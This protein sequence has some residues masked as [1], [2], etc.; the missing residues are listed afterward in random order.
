MVRRAISCAVTILV[1]ASLIWAANDPWKSKPYQQWD[2]KDLRR[3]FNDSPWAK[4]VQ[5][6]SSSASAYDSGAM[7]A[8]PSSASPAQQTRGMGA[9]D[10]T[11]SPQFRLQP[12]N[13]S[14]PPRPRMWFDGF[15]LERSAKRLYATP[16]SKAS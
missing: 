14:S 4:I 2:D 12:R 7:A 16:S 6:T 10:N 15:P 1:A 13:R 9:E 8:E 3:I 11:P 5:I